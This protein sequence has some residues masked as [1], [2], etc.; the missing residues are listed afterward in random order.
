M[1][2]ENVDKITMSREALNVLLEEAELHGAQEAQAMADRV[3]EYDEDDFR[4]QEFI[5]TFEPEQQT[6]LGVLFGR[7]LSG[8][9]TVKESLREKIDEFN[10][11]ESYVKPYY[12]YADDPEEKREDLDQTE[13]NRYVLKHDIYQRLHEEKLRRF[14][15]F[16]LHRGT[17]DVKIL[18]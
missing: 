1:A 17:V 7:A 12:A 18:D 8:W 10:A 16:G 5:K 14:G 9:K 4:A 3:A 15:L 2:N 13:F 11:F 6:P